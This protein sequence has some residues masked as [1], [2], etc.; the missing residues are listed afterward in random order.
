MKENK[1]SIGHEWS[2]VRQELFT[3]E[4]IQESDLRVQLIGEIS[5]IRKERGKIG[6][7]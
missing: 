4:E 5:K 1:S 3:K 6:R 7:D 2:E